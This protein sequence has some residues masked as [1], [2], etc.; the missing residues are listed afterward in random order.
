MSRTIP[1]LIAAYQAAEA[2]PEIQRAVTAFS[3][4]ATTASA[5][6]TVSRARISLSSLTGLA[7]WG[8]SVGLP[9]NTKTLLHPDVVERYVAI[10]YHRRSNGGWHTL[11]TN[12]RHL[13]REL[14]PALYP[15]EPM[16][17]PRP[18][19]RDPY[20]AS[21]VNAYLHLAQAQSTPLRR[22]RATTLICL[23]AGAG[24]TAAEMREAYTRDVTDD[25]DRLVVTV[26]GKE[27][28]RVVPLRRT[29]EPHLRAVIEEI[30]DGPFF[31]PGNPRLLRQVVDVLQGGRDLP[32]LEL[33]RLR[34][35]W[36]TAQ[37]VDN[38]T[39]ELFVAAGL[40]RS[41]AIFDLLELL[42]EPNPEAVIARLSDWDRS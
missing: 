28:T 10:Q 5:P 33:F 26:P 39:K 19:L 4:A 38:G 17:L 34:S 12:L 42:P 23:G 22:R 32:R 9:L 7:R 36:L 18:K 25:G 35:T 24:L 29:F 1:D 21:E 8:W 14:E 30:G 15:A 3:R 6:A 31:V 16:K 41:G 27:G 2:D 20:S 40:R 37:L 13:G 11:R